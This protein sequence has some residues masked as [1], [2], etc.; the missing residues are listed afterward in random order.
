VRAAALALAS[1]VSLASIACAD[2]ARLHS[3]AGLAYL[4]GGKDREAF[5]EFVLSLKADPNQAQPH[6]QLGRLFE[7]SGRHAE[8]IKQYRA[9]LTIDPTFPGA[10]DAVRRLDV[11]AGTSARDR[12]AADDASSVL[13]RGDLAQRIAGAGELLAAGKVEEARAVVEELARARPQDGALHRLLG[14][15]HERRR[16]LVAAAASYRAARVRLPESADLH[17][18]LAS[19]LY[20]QGAFAEA[21]GAAR[22][23]LALAPRDPNVFRMLGRIAAARR[24]KAE[25][26]R[27]LAEAARL[28]PSDAASK[29][30]SDQLAR[31]R[32]LSHFPVGMYFHSVG[33]WK[34]A[35]AELQAAL[36]TEELTLEERIEA[37]NFLVSASVAAARIRDQ[38]AQIQKDKAAREFGVLDKRL[39]FD[40]VTR[41]PSMWKDGRQVDFRGWIVGIENRERDAEVIVTTDLKDRF[42][43]NEGDALGR[44][45]DSPDIIQGFTGPVSLGNTNLL[46]VGAAG[47][48]ANTE[49]ARW[50][51]FRAPRRLPDDPRV[52]PN[53]QV[54]V[55]GTLARSAFIRNPWNRTFSRY[56]QPVIQATALE[57]RRETGIQE[58]VLRAE[59][60]IGAGATAGRQAFDTVRFPNQPEIDTPPGLAGTLKIE[61]LEVEGGVEARGAAR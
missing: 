16:D 37:Q 30:E 7:K 29:A 26:Y 20:R 49:M 55:R 32:R 19:V 59:G 51:T 33:N 57:V 11:T 50:F 52:R 2:D 6:F 12:A 47:F 14:Q 60:A 4:Y 41:Q 9:A 3:T 18:L 25:A 61:Y 1:L 35:K 39:S 10:A 46:S 56:P 44:R 34:R 17:M 8:A 40:E 31:E 13:A 27:Y 24:E 42:V 48:R 43:T 36:E 22:A 54:R 28:D 45:R 38:I 5:N 58:P 53:S 15:I 21:D 23:A